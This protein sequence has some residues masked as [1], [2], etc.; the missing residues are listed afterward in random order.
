MSR[1]NV[2]V[3]ESM[4]P[5]VAADKGNTP[6]RS[7]NAKAIFKLAN[8]NYEDRSGQRVT[9]DQVVLNYTDDGRLQDSAWNGRH[10]VTPSH[11]NFK[12]S[13]F[14][15]QYFDKEFKNTERVMINP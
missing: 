7:K 13:R 10:H 12:N 11:F 6:L 3:F 9:K 1:Q 8:G 14:Y 4:R 2:M 15:K 5:P